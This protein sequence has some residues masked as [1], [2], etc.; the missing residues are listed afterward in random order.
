[1][2]AARL[3]FQQ[4]GG[5]WQDPRV[6][7]VYK[8]RLGDRDASLVARKKVGLSVR[9]WIACCGWTIILVMLLLLVVLS[10]ETAIQIL[11]VFFV[12]Y[13]IQ[14]Y[15]AELIGV[16]IESS[17][18]SFPNRVFPSFPYLVLF[19]S[20]LP[21]RSF[22]RVDFV[23]RQIVIVYPARRQINIPATKSCDEKRVV[24][25]LRDTFPDLSVTILH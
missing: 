7:R 8:M 21:R 10:T 5:R 17:G 6:Q 3:S 2:F 16:K 4:L 18:I 13:G 23:K 25:F 24:R 11:L 15:L 22:N 20:K 19:R 12:V 1:M 14:G 9:S